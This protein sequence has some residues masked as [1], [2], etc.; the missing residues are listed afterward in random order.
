MSLGGDEEGKKIRGNLYKMSL[1]IKC[2]EKSDTVEN[3][4]WFGCS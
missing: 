3:K 1:N 4:V 2:H